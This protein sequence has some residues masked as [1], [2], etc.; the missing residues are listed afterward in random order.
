LSYPSFTVTY[1]PAH[2]GPTSIAKPSRP[3]TMPKAMVTCFNPNRSTRMTVSNGVVRPKNK[4]LQ[5]IF[6]INL[7]F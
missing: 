6:H 7:K 3:V 2:A 1:S 5:I 4:N